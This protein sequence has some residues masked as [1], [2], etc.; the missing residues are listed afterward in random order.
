MIPLKA[1]IKK[2]RN[3]FLARLYAI[4]LFQWFYLFIARHKH[5]LSYIIIIKNPKTNI[6]SK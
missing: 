3:L 6:Y 2:N 4:C 1:L 5:F